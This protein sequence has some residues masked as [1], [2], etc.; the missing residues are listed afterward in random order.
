M[1]NWTHIIIHHS[2]TGDSTLADSVAIKRF[3]T[4]YRHYGDIVTPEEY[5]KLKEQGVAGLVEPWLDIGYHWI[6]E[7]LS[8]GYP[9]VIAG[10][11]MYLSGAHTV[12]MNSVGIGVCFVGN[13]DPEP[14]A[15]DLLD[16]GAEHVAWLC[17]IYN[18]PID[19]VQP[20][21]RYASYKSCPGEQ[22]DMAKFQE[23]VGKFLGDKYGR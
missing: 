5:F 22:F 12:G 4:S 3:H 16:K 9:W 2:F 17:S 19:N 10:R 6:V 8:S 1:P 21:R 13:F 20:H 18:I 7:R 14:P 23:R 15:E 11:P